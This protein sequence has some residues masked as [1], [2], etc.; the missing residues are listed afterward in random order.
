ML[1]PIFT[2]A[3]RPCDTS[4]VL[5]ALNKLPPTAV[6]PIRD[7]VSGYL[8][9][10]LCPTLPSCQALTELCNHRP[11]L[12]PTD[13]ARHLDS[14]VKH[15]MQ[16]LVIIHTSLQPKTPRRE[17]L[18]FNLMRTRSFAAAKLQQSS[19]GISVTRTQRWNRL[20]G[21]L[22]LWTRCAGHVSPKASFQARELAGY[23]EIGSYV[24]RNSK[25]VIRHT[26]R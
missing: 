5:A 2:P 7:Q 15:R 13:K 11:R 26:T 12:M 14:R 6:A 21:S 22:Q 20:L 9:L 8:I 19:D 18:S 25:S 24:S 23:D 4:R 10:P 16:L 17:S 1:W 3:K